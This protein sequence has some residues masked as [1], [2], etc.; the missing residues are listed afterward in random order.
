MSNNI[1]TVTA[2]LQD[3]EFI[4]EEIDR[5]FN[6]IIAKHFLCTHDT[7]STI[8][9]LNN[10]KQLT[11]YIGNDDKIIDKNII[12]KKTYLDPSCISDKIFGQIIY[13]QFLDYFYKKLDLSG[14]IKNFTNLGSMLE[15]LFKIKNILPSNVLPV[16]NVND[17][18]KINID[19]LKSQNLI[20]CYLPSKNCIDN[21][22]YK[23]IIDFLSNFTGLYKDVFTNLT[24]SNTSIDAN[25]ELIRFILHF[26][27]LVK[28]HIT[29]V[30]DNMHIYHRGANLN[31]SS[32]TRNHFDQ[33]IIV[34]QNLEKFLQMHFYTDFTTHFN[35]TINKFENNK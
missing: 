1:N 35:K 32:T 10:D 25:N 21:V 12:S 28:K 30:C 13:T 29:E 27:Q 4:E 14:G 2:M 20:L 24:I 22:F 8:S 11:I 15:Y 33:F 34:K 16:N 9:N 6:K 3:N 19:V 17:T 23:D 7:C 26:G 31:K 5:P 18:K